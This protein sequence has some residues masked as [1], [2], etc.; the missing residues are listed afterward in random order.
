MQKVWDATIRILR[1]SRWN[2]CCYFGDH[3]IDTHTLHRSFNY[4]FSLEMRIK[5]KKDHDRL[6]MFSSRSRDGIRSACAYNR[7]F[8]V[9]DGMRSFSHPAMPFHTVLRAFRRL[10]INILEVCIDWNDVYCRIT[11]FAWNCHKPFSHTKTRNN[12]QLSRGS[13]PSPSHAQ[14]LNCSYRYCSLMRRAILYEKDRLER[15]NGTSPRMESSRFGAV[16][17]FSQNFLAVAR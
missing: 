16:G 14:A 2:L 8:R 9:V 15:P 10:N 1:I 4:R 11:K 17:R 13:M 3:T 5:A 6:R 7:R 12:C